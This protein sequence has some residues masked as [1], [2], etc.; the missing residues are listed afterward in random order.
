MK[1]LWKKGLVAFLA[2]TLIFQLIPGFANA[3]DSRLKDG[4]EYQVQVNFYKDN[5]GKTTKESSEADKYIDHTATI[6][7]ENGQPYMYLTITNSTW[8]Q[9]MAVSKNGA[10]PEKPAQADVYQDRYEDV[11]TVSTD[12]AKDTRVEKFK[13]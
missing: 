3:A 7:V 12:A 10:R 9:T 8:W 1:K 5:T 2:L 11:Q 4:G 6:K 13:L